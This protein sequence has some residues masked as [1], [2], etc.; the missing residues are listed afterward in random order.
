MAWSRYQKRKKLGICVSCGMECVGD[1][2]YCLKHAEE[3]RKKANKRIKRLKEA[4]LCLICEEPSFEKALCKK[5]S[6]EDTD[7][8]AA[9]RRRR[10]AL[11]VCARCGLNSPRLGFQNC[12]ECY[13][14]QKQRRKD[15]GFFVRRAR[16]IIGGLASQK[17]PK[18]PLKPLELAVA[19]RCLWKE[20][21]GICALSGRKLTRTNCEVDHITPRSEGGLTIESNL[22]FLHKD[23]NQAL[24]SLTDSEFISICID[25]ASFKRKKL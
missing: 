15:A 3:N 22:R 5:C 16:S 11:G 23:V 17:M 24:R 14:K 10:A 7:R 13:F 6:A 18:S 1:G 20:Q 25:V 8:Q 2:V 12:E 4:N 21:K 9:M 19:L